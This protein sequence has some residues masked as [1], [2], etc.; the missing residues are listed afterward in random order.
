MSDKHA[1][2]RANNRESIKQKSREWRA[3]N[4]AEARKYQREWARQPAARA[5]HSAYN[6]SKRGRDVKW[7]A[8]IKNKHGLSRDQHQNIIDSQGGVCVGCYEVFVSRKLTHVDHDH[9]R[10]RAEGNIRGIL[11]AHCNRALGAVR[12]RVSVLNNL[13]E[14]LKERQCGL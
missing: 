12:D 10:T 11:C 9:S 3:A 14:Y 8:K 1:K 6:H 5:K 2:W 7:A 4:L 13:I